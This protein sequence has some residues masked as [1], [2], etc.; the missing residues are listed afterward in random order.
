MDLC[1]HLEQVM[2]L[3]YLDFIL[4][5][6][7]FPNNS[8]TLFNS[9]GGSDK[10]HPQHL[11]NLLQPLGDDLESPLLSAAIWF[12]M[13]TLQWRDRSFLELLYWP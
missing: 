4:E 7:V 10:L 1:I 9:Y 5:N 12:C 13:R 3:A 6:S 8:G 11:E 2:N